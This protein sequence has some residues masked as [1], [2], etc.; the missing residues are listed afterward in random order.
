M[1]PVTSATLDITVTQS[2]QVGFAL[3]VTKLKQNKEEIHTF[4]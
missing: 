2:R 1:I 3:S 4:S